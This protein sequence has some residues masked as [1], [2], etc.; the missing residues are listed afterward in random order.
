MAWYDN[1]LGRLS[2]KKAEAPEIFKAEAEVEKSDVRVTAERASGGGQYNML[3]SSSYDG[4]KNVGEIGPIKNYIIDY[5]SLRARSWQLYLESEIAQTVLKKYQTWMIGKGLKLQ[6]EPAKQVLEAESIKIDHQKFSRN[7]EMRFKIFSKS[8][9]SDYSGMSNLNFIEG[10]AFKNAIVGGDVLVIL[11]FTDG[12]PNVQLIDGAHVVSPISGSDFYPRALANGNRIIN[13]IELSPKNEHVA[14][15]VRNIN[16]TS[17][18]FFN[19]Y[20][21]ITRVKA[22]S[23]SGLLMAFMVYGSRYRLD[24]HRGLPLLSVIFETAKKL[25]R[26]KE[27]TL[28][29]AEERQKIAYAIEHEYFSTGE[30]PLLR[31]TLRAYDTSRSGDAIPVDQLGNQI[32]DRFTATTN[33]QAFNLPLGAHLKALESKNELYFKDFYGTN[34]DVMCSSIEIPPEVALSKYNSNFSASRAALKDWENTLLTKRE[35]F[36]FQFRQMVYNY[37]LHTEILKGKIDAP[38]YLQAVQADDFMVVESYRNARFVGAPVPHIDPMKEVN[39]ERLKLGD[40]AGSI[41]LTTVEAST[42]S[43]NGGESDAN[44]EQFAEELEMSKKFGLKP[45][46]PIDPNKVPVDKKKKED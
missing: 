44:M 6:S 18:N 23:R 26:Y 33:K 32:A 1:I 29:S 41:P 14:Y 42:E 13:G 43:L 19:A 3:F 28:G 15:Y 21:N 24:N 10:E 4:E 34:I 31:Q 8:K 5:D 35:F 16:N 2:L 39:A 11:R 30:D 37:W 38:G 27:A 7:V 9:K 36:G 46:I 40:T 25:E 22:K 45:E 17:V 12:C 20:S